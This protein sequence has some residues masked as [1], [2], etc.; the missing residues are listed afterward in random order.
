MKL[1]ET[2]QYQNI[3]FQLP[4][5]FEQDYNHDY[6]VKSSSLTK[7]NYVIGINFSVEHFTESDLEKPFIKENGFNINPLNT[8]H[9]A[10]IARRYNS[11][12]DGGIAIK[13]TFNK[14]KNYKGLIQMVSG[15]DEYSSDETYYATATIQLDKDYYVFQWITTQEM[16]SYVYDDFERVLYS[17]KKIK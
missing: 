1:E 10:Y 5:K 14:K 17:V 3:S 4:G 15:N 12:V 2:I 8:I 6:T 7:E 11:L 13:K 9:D 16:M